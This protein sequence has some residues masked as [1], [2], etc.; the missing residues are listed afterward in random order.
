MG[1]V[2]G[3]L[4]Q[5]SGQNTDLIATVHVQAH[6]EITLGDFLRQADTLQDR[7][8]NGAGDQPGNQGAQQQGHDQ[9]DNQDGIGC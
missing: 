2:A 7:N 8:G 5:G 1:E 9:P 4:I 6:A 3:H